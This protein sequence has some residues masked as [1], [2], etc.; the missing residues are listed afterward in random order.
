MPNIKSAKKRMKQ[1]AVRRERNRAVK[2]TIRTHYRRVL[3][4]IASGDQQKAR[5]ELKLTTIKLD[6]AAARRV[7]H[8]NAAARTKSRLS[9][10]VKAMKAEKAVSA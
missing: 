9:A 7:I 4:A 8:A 2:R 5:E 6:R 3:D 10:K 1:D